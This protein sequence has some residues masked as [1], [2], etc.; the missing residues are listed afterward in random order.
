[1]PNPTRIARQAHCFKNEGEFS[2]GTL[3]AHSTRHAV[4]SMIACLQVLYEALGKITVMESA[5]RNAFR[6][7][8]KSIIRACLA[9]IGL[10]RPRSALE[11]ASCLIAAYKDTWGWSDVDVAEAEMIVAVP[12]TSPSSLTDGTLPG[13]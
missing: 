3:P 1:M 7:C 2:N 5:A 11:Q 8:P 9:D 12:A 4:Q 10:Q 13:L 6:H